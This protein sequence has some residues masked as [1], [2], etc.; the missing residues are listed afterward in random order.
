MRAL[1]LAAITVGALGLEASAPA[2]A[3][4]FVRSKEA[5]SK[6]GGK[7]TDIW[8]GRYFCET[9]KLDR[10]CARKNNGKDYEWSFNP[11]AGK[12]KYEKYVDDGCDLFDEDC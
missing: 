7:I 4:G 1:L 6:L 11:K 12:C 8:Q 9:L 10:E 5:C 2:A 3:G